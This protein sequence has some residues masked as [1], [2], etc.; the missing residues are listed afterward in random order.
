MRMTVVEQIK[1]F[2]STQAT[3]SNLKKYSNTD[4]PITTKLIAPL[5]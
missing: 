5:M 1:T 2:S 3:N 4:K